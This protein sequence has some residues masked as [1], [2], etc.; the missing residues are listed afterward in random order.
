MAFVI[1]V[2]VC[3]SHYYLLLQ[4]DLQSF[5]NETIESETTSFKIMSWIWNKV[6]GGGGIERKLDRIRQTESELL[7]FAKQYGSDN[8]NDK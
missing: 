6:T 3:C 4:F 8:D 7:E 1:V 2:V 5:T